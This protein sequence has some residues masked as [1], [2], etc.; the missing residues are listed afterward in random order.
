MSR[1]LEIQKCS[2]KT[3]WRLYKQLVINRVAFQTVEHGSEDV[4]VL[5]FTEFL[6]TLSAL[7]GAFA[8]TL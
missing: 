7:D 1:A 2:G 5:L 8:G 4:S 6:L 3:I